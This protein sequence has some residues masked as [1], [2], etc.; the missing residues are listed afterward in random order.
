M[1]HISQKLR[2]HKRRDFRHKQSTNE[3]PGFDFI[4]TEKIDQSKL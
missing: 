2:K 3:S 4:I 1:S